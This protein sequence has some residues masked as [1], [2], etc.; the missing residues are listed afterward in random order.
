MNNCI[1]LQDIDS[2]LGCGDNTGGI[3]K[4]AMFYH[5]DVASWPIHKIRCIWQIY[6]D[7]SRL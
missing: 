2:D 7:K 1:E 6:K 5:N 3:L 4:V